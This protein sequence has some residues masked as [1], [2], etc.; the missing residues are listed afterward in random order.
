MRSASMP[1]ELVY[2]TIRSTEIFFLRYD[3]CPCDGR[4]R[5]SMDVA[6]VNIRKM[7]MSVRDRCM[8]MR[9][10]VRLFTVPW[11][12]VFMLMMRV[13]SMTM[14]MA[15]RFVRVRMLVAFADMQPYAENHQRG[16]EPELPRRRLGPQQPRERHAE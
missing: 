2:R 9:M 16:R 13:V 1:I 4:I 15:E 11:E 5:R 7:R 8:V 10:G 3:E 6:V 12:I 14:R